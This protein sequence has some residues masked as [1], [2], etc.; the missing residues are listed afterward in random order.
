MELDSVFQNFES[1]TQKDLKLN[2]KKFF[3]ESGLTPKD[4]GFVML[5]CAYSVNAKP[6]IEFGILHLKTHGA[7]DE[8]IA[9]VKDAAAIMGTMNVYYRF[10]HW[11]PK[12]TYQKPAGLR[13]NV[14]ARPVTGK[15]S[16]EQMAL[17]VSMV[18]GCEACVKSHE[19]SV[20]QHGVTE[21]QVH[22][23][24]RLAATVKA[25][26]VHLR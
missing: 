4:A 5:A 22:D 18:N 10:R 17:A 21:D 19:Q 8:E 16:F 26:E 2:F 20:L 23:I 13:M 6:L 25:L 1:P 7:S 24:A 15:A 9:E 14:M 3:L 12:E 11:V